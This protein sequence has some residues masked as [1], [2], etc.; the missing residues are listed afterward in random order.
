[1]EILKPQAGPSS[2]HEP[3]R[4]LHRPE[5]LKP[6]H[7][8]LVAIQGQEEQDHGHFHRHHLQRLL[9]GYLAADQAC[10]SVALVCVYIYYI[11]ACA[12]RGESKT[13][14][15]HDSFKA[16]QVDRILSHK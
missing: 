1:M 7:P 12:R 9:I 5:T 11:Y 14:F 6:Q 10:I 15:Q 8:E 16:V 3:S 13:L 4:T 2:L